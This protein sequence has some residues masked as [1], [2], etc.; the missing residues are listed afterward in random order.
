VISRLHNGISLEE[1]FVE[2]IWKK[3]GLCEPF[4]RF[5][6]SRHEEYN[7]RAMQGAERTKDGRLQPCD[8]WPFDNAE[9]MEGGSGLA[10]TARDFIAVLADLVSASPTLLKLA[11]VEEMFAP[12][13]V[14]GSPSVKMLLDLRVAWEAVAGPISEDAVNHGLGGLLCTGPVPEVR[15]PGS[16]LAWGG[17]TNVFWWANREKGVAGF[18]ATQ[19]GPFGNPAVVEVVNAWKKDFWS[20][21]EKGANTEDS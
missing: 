21:F 11:T 10:A 5:N 12:Q 4:P 16:M 17:A 3:L 20:Q 6:I 15:Q 18:F 9:D 19:Q 1:Y 8:K 7:A 13:L 2:N 14:P